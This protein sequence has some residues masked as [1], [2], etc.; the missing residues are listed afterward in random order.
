[1]RMKILISLSIFAILIFFVFAFKG[2][3]VRQTQGANP[4]A[5]WPARNQLWD[6]MFRRR[7]LLTVYSAGD[8]KIAAAYRG[9]YQNLPQRERDWLKREYL[10]DIEFPSDSLSQRPITVVGAINTNQVLQRLLPQLPIE[11]LPEGFRFRSRI[12]RAPDDILALTYPNPLN[13]NQA[14]SIVTGNSDEAILESFRKNLRRWRRGMG[15]YRIEQQNETTLYGYFQDSGAGAWDPDSVREYDLRRDAKPVKTTAH[16]NFLTHGKNF[17]PEA[18]EKLAARYEKS[19]NQ[20]AERLAVPK[21][22]LE[23]L[24]RLAVHLWDS[25]E[26]KGMFTFNTDLRHLDTTRNAAHLLYLPDLRGDDFFA[27]AS[28]F[29]TQLLGAGKSAALHEGLAVAFSEPWRG[30]GYSGWAARLVQTQNAP[31]LANLF[32][33]ELRLQESELVRQPLLGSFAALLLEK[34]GAEELAALYREWPE[35]GVPKRFANDPAWENLI[36]AWQNKLQNTPAIPLRHVQPPKIGAHD[37]HRGFNYAH[38]GYDIHN[39]YLGGASRQALEKLAALSVNAITVTPFGFMQ[40]PKVP[41]FPGRSNG[42]YGESDESVI[43]AKNFAREFRMRAMLKPH[44]WLGRGWPGDI[45]MPTP[46]AW[47]TFFDYYDCWMRGYAVLAEMYDFDLLCVG[48]EMAKATVGHEPEWRQ[49]IKRWRGIYSGPM[50]YAANWGQ[51]FETVKFW[52]ALDAIG[53]DCY[54]PLSIKDDPTDAELLAGAKMVVEKIRAVAAAYKK[55]VLVTEIGFTS[56]AFPWKNP[57]Q[58]DRQAAVD[59]EAQRRCYEAIYQA[60]FN[61]GS[62]PNWLAGMYW[63]KWPSSLD[64][65][66]LRDRQFTPNGKPAAQVAAKWYK[67]LAREFPVSGQ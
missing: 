25:A 18:V 47:K 34:F 45:E 49:M 15:D 55:P 50:V 60:F 35:T 16:F 37:F 14:L 28:W 4:R 10:G 9:Y 67:Q 17:S 13:P 41:A 62:N 5:N 54:Y 39:G 8:A 48:V 38:E 21:N 44:I 43:V 31:P 63:W 64:E 20:I 27:E 24:P 2:S 57:H 36:A 32:D 29:V 65:G 51:E 19:L 58:E 23:A 11:R 61:S 52:E 53:I 59:L 46:A 56:S 3:E 6:S 33:N 1:M 12:Y 30:I 66:G 40:E 42:P 22:K 7:S 26:E